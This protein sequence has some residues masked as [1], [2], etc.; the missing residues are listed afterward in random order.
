M[1]LNIHMKGT[2]R[3]KGRS[4]VYCCTAI[5]L[6][7]I[8]LQEIP[9]IFSNIL[10]KFLP[11]QYIYCIYTIIYIYTWIY[12]KVKVA[13]PFTYIIYNIPQWI[14]SVSSDI[15]NFYVYIAYNILLYYKAQR[16]YCHLCAE[17]NVCNIMLSFY[18]PGIRFIRSYLEFWWKQYS[19]CSTNEKFE[20]VPIF[21]QY[22]HYIG[23]YKLQNNQSF[24]TR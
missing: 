24:R 2:V 11:I 5:H 23:Y 10:L 9:V 22:L 18:W 17:M 8:L 3:C 21:S 6:K 15:T 7:F 19:D 1:N 16:K 13:Y 20:R 4:M 14:M 12:L